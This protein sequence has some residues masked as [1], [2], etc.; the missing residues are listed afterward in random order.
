MAVI[1]V[2]YVVDEDGRVWDWEKECPNSNRAV[3]VHVPSEMLG[4]TLPCH[5]RRNSPADL[6]D[7]GISIT[8]SNPPKPVGPPPAT[9]NACG[10][11]NEYGAEVNYPA[12]APVSFRCG[13]CRAHRGG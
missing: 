2:A 12:S 5:K 1:Q 6:R 3:H 9:C 4:A 7:L 8:F 11:P 13:Q 10:D